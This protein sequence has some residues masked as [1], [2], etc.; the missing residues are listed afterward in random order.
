[1]ID[2]IELRLPASTLFTREISAFFLLNPETETLAGRP[3]RLD[4][5][6][7]DLRPAGLDS[8]LHVSCKRG[9]R[10]QHKL[11][12][13]DT[14]KKSYSE[15]TRQVEAVRGG[16]NEQLGIMRIDFCADI[17][18]VPVSWFQQR[19]RFLHK[20]ISNQIG[21]LPYQTISRAGIE[22]I[23]AG[24]RPNIVRIYDKVAESKMQ[25]V[26]MRRTASKEADVLNFEQEFGFPEEAVITRVERQCGGG[27]IP[28]QV[29]TFGHISRAASFNPFEVIEIESS[30]R[31]RLPA[32]GE[33]DSVTEWAAGMYFNQMIQEQGKQTFQRWLN[34]ESNGNGARTVKRYKAFLPQAEGCPVTVRTIFETYRTSV[35]R[36][37]SA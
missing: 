13:L 27:R 18:G 3:S 37:L 21:P 24:K 17:H 28:E 26:K 23:S 15:L 36:Q 4:A 7:I 8:I 2:K 35:I 12:L 31:S 16:D 11:E 9:G 20:Q 10:G 32:V 25:F 34:R 1:M 30:G 22:T 5:R 29:D 33:C 6:V 19:V 14:G